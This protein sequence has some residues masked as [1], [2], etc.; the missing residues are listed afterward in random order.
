MKTQ[1]LNFVKKPK[2]IIWFTRP[3]LKKTHFW[4]MDKK[5]SEAYGKFPSCQILSIPYQ[6]L[7]IE[8]WLC[9]ADMPSTMKPCLYRMVTE[10]GYFFVKWPASKIPSGG[11]GYVSTIPGG[12]GEG[13]VCVLQEAADQC[14]IQNK[15]SAKERS[16]YTIKVILK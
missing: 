4:N 2:E 5:R 16:C 13:K 7:S 6:L 15:A 8:Q 11:V 10:P 1:F 12:R 9:K 14:E 3:L